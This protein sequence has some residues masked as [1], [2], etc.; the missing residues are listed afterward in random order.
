MNNPNILKRCKI[1]EVIELEVF[2]VLLFGSQEPP[3]HIYILSKRDTHRNKNNMDSTI[4]GILALC[5]VN[6]YNYNLIKDILL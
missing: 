5:R 4:W 1:S 6:N 2:A 3:P